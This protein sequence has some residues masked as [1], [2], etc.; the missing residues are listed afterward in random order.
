MWKEAG[1]TR[2]VVDNLGNERSNIPLT[3]TSI[4]NIPVIP[5][6]STDKKPIER[7]SLAVKL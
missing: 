7:A 1:I 3:K 5:L 6:L 4:P 2:L